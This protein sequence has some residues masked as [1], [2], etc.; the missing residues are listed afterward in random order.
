MNLVATNICEKTTVSVIFGPQTLVRIE[1]KHI[2]SS[3]VGCHPTLLTTMLVTGT[4]ITFCSG[5]DGC[6]LNDIR[7]TFIIYLHT[8]YIPNL[9]W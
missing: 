6:S 9:T 8:P 4:T 2:S 1:F 7:S 3:T 5:G